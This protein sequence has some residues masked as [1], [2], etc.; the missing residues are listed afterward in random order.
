M[1]CP[2]CGDNLEPVDTDRFQREQKPEG[3]RCLA[4]HGWEVLH[5]TNGRLLLNGS[6]AFD[7]PELS[8]VVD[9]ECKNTLPDSRL[10]TP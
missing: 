10:I 1:F 9:E 8:L 7:R 2:M 3:W 6:A 4:G 5:Y